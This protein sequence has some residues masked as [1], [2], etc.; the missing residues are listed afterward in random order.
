MK[1]KLNNK[2]LKWIYSI[3]SIICL[4]GFLV[5]L[6]RD[7]KGIW[8]ILTG[9]SFCVSFLFSHFAGKLTV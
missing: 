1:M 8:A 5:G 6:W 2:I 3:V 4:I 7:A 9:L